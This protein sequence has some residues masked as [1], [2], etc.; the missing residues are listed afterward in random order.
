MIM[1]GLW[2][3]MLCVTCYVVATPMDNAEGR[4]GLCLY[5]PECYCHFQSLEHNCCC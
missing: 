2:I 4:L 1:I 5:G 3:T